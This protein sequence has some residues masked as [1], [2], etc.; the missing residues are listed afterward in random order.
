[1]FS[2]VQ[3]A[4]LF[5][6]NSFSD[7]CNSER[8][9]QENVA[10]LKLS[11]LRLLTEF[12]AQTEKGSEVVRWSYKYYDASC[13]KPDTTRKSFL[14]FNKK[15]FDDFENDLTDRFYTAFDTKQGDGSAGGKSGAVQ[16]DLPSTIGVTGNKPHCYILNK[17]FQEV[18]H[19]YNWDI[20][21]ISSP[22]KSNRRRTQNKCKLTPEIVGPY[23][24]VIVYTNIPK[25]QNELRKFCGEEGDVEGTADNFM[26]EIL[27][28]ATRS[29]FQDGKQ[30]RP[31]FINLVDLCETDDTNLFNGI[32]IGLTKLQGGLFNITSLVQTEPMCIIQNGANNVTEADSILQL[33]PLP[34]QPVVGAAY[35]VHSEWWIKGKHGRARK[36][37]PGPSLIWEDSQGTSFLQAQLEV[38]AVQGSSSR[39]WSD[40]VVVGVVQ[41]NAVSLVAVAGGM[42]SLYVCHAPNTVFTTLITNLAKYQLAMLLRLGC[43]GLALLC[44]WAGDVG[45]LAVVSSSGLAVPPLPSTSQ[46]TDDILTHFAVE[47]VK[48]CLGAA[49]AHTKSE[50]TPSDKRFDPQKTERWFCPE[51]ASLDTLRKIKKKRTERIER[52]IMLERL[53]KKYR[54][55][56]PQPLGS[57]ENSSSAFMAPVM[58]ADI[59]HMA[60][61]TQVASGKKLPAGK[62]LSISRAQQLMQ[63]SRVVT[64][65]QKF[66]NPHHPAIE[67]R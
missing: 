29:F 33:F 28:P 45:C 1:M 3:V 12:G 61:G 17:S 46:Q 16:N 63:N 38:L 57:A 65:Q 53:Q 54:P 9:L 26:D 22:V 35:S 58:T 55:Q 18:V 31:Y 67:A 36:P 11:S 5:D 30:I 48:R 14:D 47:I 60:S 13:F 21:D 2:S 37:Q 15:S 66:K 52:K 32:R 49:P 59:S 44:P 27:D 6:V 19:D 40:A 8:E 25:N 62:K 64:A 24:A 43:G 34:S 41:L 50:P 20:P 51:R 7:I 23:N 42:G 10:R 56:I 4:L 39:A